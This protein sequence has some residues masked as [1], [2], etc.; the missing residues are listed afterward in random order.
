MAVL[1]DR[2]RETIWA[3][4]MS[5]A[6]SRRD[7]VGILKR[8]YRAAVDA[9]DD[10]VEADTT[11]RTNSF[12]VESRAGLTTKQ[13]LEVFYRVARRKWELAR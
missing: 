10:H 9:M 12:P 7:S 8:D 3:G 2:D 11:D 5:D 4:L 1:S 13:Q 6:S